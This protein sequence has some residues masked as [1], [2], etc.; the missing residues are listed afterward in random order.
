MMFSHWCES[1]PKALIFTYNIGHERPHIEEHSRV[2]ARIFDVLLLLR[3]RVLVGRFRI[4][5]FMARKERRTSFQRN[6]AKICRCVPKLKMNYMSFIISEYCEISLLRKLV[7][8]FE[9]VVMEVPL[10]PHFVIIPLTAKV[11]PFSAIAIR[12]NWSRE[13][14]N[15]YFCVHCLSWCGTP[16]LVALEYTNV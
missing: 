10:L 9:G 14:Q 3:C 8:P 7:H 15:L 11:F 4:Q 1:L 13:I 5:I 12:A 2:A 16:C 6:S